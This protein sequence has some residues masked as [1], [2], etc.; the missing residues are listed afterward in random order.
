MCDESECLL[1]LCCAKSDAMR[2]QAT[3]IPGA[4]TVVSPVQS[5]QLPDVHLAWIHGPQSLGKVCSAMEH[6]LLLLQPFVFSAISSPL[7]CVPFS[8]IPCFLHFLKYAFP[9]APPSWLRGSAVPSA[10]LVGA[11]WNPPCPAQGSPGFSQRPPHCQCIA[12]CTR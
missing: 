4:V 6:L 3:N 5:L 1:L 2:N 11:G 10:G 8:S 7:L 9:E 12:I